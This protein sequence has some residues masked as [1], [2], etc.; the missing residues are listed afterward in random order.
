MQAGRSVGYDARM[1]WYY[2]AHG[3][4]EGPVDDTTIQQLAR[5]GRLEPASLVWNP[6]VSAEWVPARTVP[7]LAA[8]FAGAPAAPAAPAFTTPPSTFPSHITQRPAADFTGPDATNSELT[9]RARESLSGSWGSAIGLIVIAYVLLFAVILISSFIPLANLVA[10]Y[11]LM[12]PIMVGVIMFFLSLLRREP[13][14]VGQL[15]GGFAAFGPSVLAQLLLALIGLGLVLVLA[16]PFIAAVAAILAS[17]GGLSALFNDGPSPEMAR[18]I[19][20]II[21]LLVIFYVLLIV[22][23]TWIQLRFSMVWAI[24]ADRPSTGAV[25]AL[26]R[27][28]QIMRGRKWK[29]FCLMFRFFGWSLLAMLTCG[30]GF[31]WVIPYMC[32]SYTAFYEDAAPRTPES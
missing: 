20:S 6:E 4:P 25:A 1:P 18:S 32:A 7:L 9:R 27:S 13:V 29:L 26:R 23:V 5:D 22:V 30:I 15:F 17:S 10:Q 2:A 31:L 21:A 19:P 14:N 24:L 11:V 28:V 8:V 3:K 16:I 12:P